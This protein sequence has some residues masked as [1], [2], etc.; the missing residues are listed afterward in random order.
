MLWLLIGLGALLLLI[1]VFGLLKGGSRV[2]SVYAE[3]A[4]KRTI[5]SS[6][7]ESG[8][9]EPVTEVKIAPDVSGEVVELPFKEGTLVRKGDLL[10]TIRPDNYRSAVEQATASLNGAIANQMTSKAT[11]GQSRANYLQDSANF[12]RNRELFEKGVISKFEFENY[13]LKLA[14]SQSQFESAKQSAQ[15]AFYQIENARASLRQAQQNL[16]RTSISASMDGT[17]TRINVKMGERA[18]GTSMMAGTE[19][20][21]IAD[22]S[23]MRVSVEINENDIVHLK[24]GDSAHVKIDAYEGKIFKGKVSEIAYSAS[25]SLLGNTTGGDQVTNFV[26]K[27]EIEPSSYVN[28]KEIMRGI[29]AHQSPFRPGMSAQVEIF[30]ERLD[31]V[32]AIPIQ[33]VTIEKKK[34]GSADQKTAGQKAAP[35]MEEP[36]EIVYVVVNSKKVEVRPVRTGISD[37]KYIAI[38][39]GLKE[40]ETVV[41]GPYSVLTQNLKDGATVKISTEDKA[42]K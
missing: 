30:T 9:V 33:S 28:D 13:Q 12:V 5:L 15:A 34:N 7:T 6:V 41:T 25:E 16:Q 27:V 10:V 1:F 2:P 19:I 35:T 40:G 22:L 31:N 29:E 4:E 32:L 14:V 8:T 42:K 39:E 38:L 37:D 18:V 17:I 3:K 20:L 23:K 21:R 26:V 11:I 24:I 36:R